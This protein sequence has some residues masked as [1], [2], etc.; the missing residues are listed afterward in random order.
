MLQ[1][2]P[3]LRV[4]EMVK[5][6]GS[7]FFSYLTQVNSQ[8]NRTDMKS[9]DRKCYPEVSLRM[10]GNGIFKVLLLKPGHVCQRV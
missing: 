7:F 2:V 1:F 9:S 8:Q 3:R 6:D 4:K 5:L 10:T